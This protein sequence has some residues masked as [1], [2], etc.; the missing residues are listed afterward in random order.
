M[1][2]NILVPVDLSDK[3]SWRKAL[4]TAIALCQTFQ[5][6]LHVIA[7]VPEFGLPMVGQF[8]PEGYEDKLRQQA[9]KQL[10][11][12]V[13]EQVPDEVPT[14]RIIA[15]GRIYREILKAAQTIRA[16][17]IVMGSHHPELKDYL[18]GPNADKVMRHAD[19]SVMVVRE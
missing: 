18:L 5:A 17:L 11:A 13:A 15:E 19:C 6:R 10:K 9:A 8:F 1:Y 12:L 7:V 16:D 14:R 2:R 4:P 3:H